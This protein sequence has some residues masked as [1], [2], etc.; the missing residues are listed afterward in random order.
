M[1]PEQYHKR[2]GFFVCVMFLSVPVCF[3]EG[4]DG[5]LEAR[6]ICDESPRRSFEGLALQGA[7]E[8]VGTVEPLKNQAFKSPLQKV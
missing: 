2:Q 3:L 5:C 6:Q 4:L 7:E 1:T 8:F